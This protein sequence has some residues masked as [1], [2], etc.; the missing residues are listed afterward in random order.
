MFSDILNS[1]FCPSSM[2]SMFISWVWY[3]K[4]IWLAGHAYMM[5]ISGVLKTLAVEYSVAVLVRP[6]IL[7]VMLY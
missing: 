6:D 5:H 1:D 2:M 4:F 3:M 7:Y